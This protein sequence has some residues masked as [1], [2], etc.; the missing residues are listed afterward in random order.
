M[1]IQYDNTWDESCL[2]H[3][4]GGQT[5]DAHYAYMTVGTATPYWRM[6]LC[7]EIAHCLCS[8]L[9]KYHETKYVLRREII[10]WRI[11]KSF[12]KAKYWNEERAKKGLKSYAKNWGIKV[13]WD[14]LR[15]I[16]LNTNR[17]YSPEF[18]FK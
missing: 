4:W 16:P 3:N 12:C 1:Y 10:A 9:E 7:H 17:W 14:K 18:K 8:T 2:Y 15:I 13:N 5:G 6:G 11:S